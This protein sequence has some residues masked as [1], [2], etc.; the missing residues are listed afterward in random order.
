MWA[1]LEAQCH[2]RSCCIN[3]FQEGLEGVEI[4][5]SEAV[6]GA[7]RCLV[8]DMVSIACR[9][10]HEIE[11]IAEVRE[12]EAKAGGTICGGPLRRFRR[13]CCILVP[14]VAIAYGIK[15]FICCLKNKKTCG[16][17]GDGRSKSNVYLSYNAM[18][19]DGDPVPIIYDFRV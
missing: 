16:R 15:Q 6:G 9:M 10:P 4:L 7:L 8:D 11:R 3:E 12:G 13:A 17:K 14:A 1:K 19:K 18:R 5:R 2:R